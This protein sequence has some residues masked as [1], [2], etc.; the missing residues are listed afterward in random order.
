MGRTTVR[1]ETI[2]S[3]GTTVGRRGRRPLHCVV[4]NQ[5]DKLKIWRGKLPLALAE[6]L[7][8]NDLS[9]PPKK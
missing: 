3:V 5:L 8:Y 9:Q 6:N 1:R 4:F 2:V 7:Y